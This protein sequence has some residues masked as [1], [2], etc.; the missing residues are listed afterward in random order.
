MKILTTIFMTIVLCGCSATTAVLVPVAA[1]AVS[2]ARD[3]II[4]SDSCEG[5]HTL[6]GCGLR[7][8]FDESTPR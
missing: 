1:D 8:L 3:I 7:A 6:V 4:D 2:E 5:S